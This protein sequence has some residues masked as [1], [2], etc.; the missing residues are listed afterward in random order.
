MAS[1]LIQQYRDYIKE[2]T[3]RED[4][5]PD[6][7]LAKDLVESPDGEFFLGRDPELQSA[8]NDYKEI[9]AG[10]LGDE[11]VQGAQRG[12]EQT[13]A[14]GAGS[15]GLLG[16][17][18]DSA[19]VEQGS[20]VRDWGVRK[21]TEYN[22]N[23]SQ[24]S[25]TF[26]LKDVTDPGEFVRWAASSLG[27]LAPD[28]ASTVVTT[29]GGAVIGAA[30]GNAPGAVA[31]AASGLVAGTERGIVT[32]LVR[33]QL[34]KKLGQ[35]GFEKLLKEGGEKL[36]ER[37]T[38]EALTNL[39]V[40]SMTRIAATAEPTMQSIGETWNQLAEAGEEV[41]AEERIAGSLSYGL[42]GGSL[43]SVLPNIG[44][45]KLNKWFGAKTFGEARRKIIDKAP[46]S[47]KKRV[48][49][50]AMTLGK[51]TG[52]EGLTEA[53]QELIQEAALVDKRDEKDVFD[54]KSYDWDT[55]KDR[56]IE[57]G[58]QGALGGFFF[59][60]AEAAGNVISSPPQSNRTDNPPAP[61]PT[62]D[63]Q[64]VPTAPVSVA[65][66]TVPKAASRPIEIAPESP[67]EGLDD[68]EVDVEDTAT[69]PA[70]T[71]VAD[72]TVNE[73]Q[74][75][76][77]SATTEAE[78][79]VDETPNA[80]PVWAT[81]GLKYR[82]ENPNSR[83]SD[84][85]KVFEYIVT[86]SQ[87]R[88]DEGDSTTIRVSDINGKKE[89]I[90]PGMRPSLA[91]SLLDYAKSQGYG[92][93]PDSETF[94]TKIFKSET[95]PVAPFVQI[96]KNNSTNQKVAR[97]TDHKSNSSVSRN[98]VV[99][100]D[101]S[102]GKVHARPLVKKDGGI[103]VTDFKQSSKGP[104]DFDQ[105]GNARVSYD[106]F[107]KNENIQPIEVIR[108]DMPTVERVALNFADEATYR[109]A[110]DAAEHSTSP[111]LEGKNNVPK[112]KSKKKKDLEDRTEE[113]KTRLDEAADEIVEADVGEQLDKATH[114]T[115]LTKIFNK[116]WNPDPVTEGKSKKWKSKQLYVQHLI[117]SN[118]QF[119]DS[120]DAMV[121]TKF[122][123][124]YGENPDVWTGIDDEAALKLT[125]Q[126]IEEPLVE[127]IYEGKQAEP[128]PIATSDPRR[129][130]GTEVDGRDS[131]EVR[132]Q[133][134]TETVRT[135]EETQ[136][137]EP[138]PEPELS[139]DDRLEKAGVDQMD[140]HHLR[141]YATM[142]IRDAQ[143]RY[144]VIEQS[145]KSSAEDKSRAQKAIKSIRKQWAD[146]HIFP[147]MSLDENSEEI[148][149]KLE[150]DGVSWDPN[151]GLVT[152]RKSPTPALSPIE[153]LR[154][155][156]N[157]VN[158]QALA[159]Y[160]AMADQ[161]A[162]PFLKGAPKLEQKEFWKGY[163]HAQRVTE[164]HNTLKLANKEYNAKFQDPDSEGFDLMKQAFW[165]GYKFYGD[166][167]TNKMAENDPTIHTWA[168][169]NKVPASL[170][171]G[172]TGAENKVDGVARIPAVA[173]PTSVK[174][175]QFN[176]KQFDYKLGDEE[177]AYQRLGIQEDMTVSQALEALSNSVP[178]HRLA[179]VINYLSKVPRLGTIRISIDRFPFQ[180]DEAVLYGEYNATDANNPVI[181]LNQKLDQ[182]L[183]QL[184]QTLVHEAVH[185]T[186]ADFLRNNPEHEASK[187][188]E[189]LFQL[190][191]SGN[192]NQL[193]QLGIING[194]SGTSW[195]GS[196]YAQDV[197]SGQKYGLTDVY[198]FVAEAMSNPDF[199][200]LLAGTEDPN[201]NT[202]WGNAKDTA[203]SL[204]EKFIHAVHKILESLGF[205]FPG[206]T[207][208][209]DALTSTVAGVVKLIDYAQEV[210]AYQNGAAYARRTNHKLGVDELSTAKRNVAI[211]KQED[212]LLRGLVK[213]T[214][215]PEAMVRDLIS[216]K[217]R[218][219]ETP[220][221]MIDIISQKNP[222]A[223]DSAIDN[224][225]MDD[226]NNDSAA[227]QWWD[228]IRKMQD[229]LFKT[230]NLKVTRIESAGVTLEMLQDDMKKI[231]K[232]FGDIN[233][234]RSVL[235]RRIKAF[236]KRQKLRGQLQ[237][238]NAML[239]ES[240]PELKLSDDELNELVSRIPASSNSIIDHLQALA[241]LGVNWKDVTPGEVYDAVKD[242]QQNPGYQQLTN[243]NKRSAV[244]VYNEILSNKDMA[245]ALISAGKIYSDQMDHLERRWL[246]NVDEIR[247]VNQSVRDILSIT[248][249]DTLATIIRDISRMP[250]KD[251]LALRIKQNMANLQRDYVK[252]QKQQQQW[253]IEVEAIKKLLD[254]LNQRVAAWDQRFNV[255]YRFDA[256]AGSKYVEMT[257]PLDVTG[258]EREEHVLSL[259]EGHAVTRNRVLMN[260][261]A[262][263]KINRG[264]ANPRL[265]S[266]VK[267]M[268]DKL[269]KVVIDD[270]AT[271]TFHWIYDRMLMSLSAKLGETNLNEGRNIQRMMKE[272]VA[273]FNGYINKIKPMGH[274]Y[275]A[276]YQ[277][278][279]NELGYKGHI[280]DFERQIRTPLVAMF[281]TE[282]EMYDLEDE[283]KR[284]SERIES[285]MK[286]HKPSYEFQA[287][288]IDPL[289]RRY[290]P[291]EKGMADAL[292]W[293]RE[294]L[295]L[296]VEES[297]NQRSFN[298]LTGKMEFLSRSKGVR[299]G[300]WTIPRL[301]DSGFINELAT[302]MKNLGWVSTEEQ[303]RLS[304]EGKPN[305]RE[306]LKK[307]KDGNQIK[308]LSAL[309]QIL[310]EA[311][312]RVDSVDF[313][314]M[315][316]EPHL[317]NDGFLKDSQGN[318]LS[319][320]EML[321]AWSKSGKNFDDFIAAIANIEVESQ[322]EAIEAA[323]RFVSTTVR[324][325]QN[326]YDRVVKLQVKADAE[327]NFT[328]V[329]KESSHFLTDA[330]SVE[331]MPVEY[332][333]YYNFDPMTINSHLSRLSAAKAFGIGG[334][335]LERTWDQ[336]ADRIDA[337]K[338]QADR[339]G[340]KK[341][342]L[343]LSEVEK[344]L[345]RERT[346]LK[347]F[348]DKSDFGP[349]Q[350]TKLFGEG[351]NL[352]RNGVLNN[353][354]S[355]MGNLITI[356]TDPAIAYKGVNKKTVGMTLGGM[357][358]FTKSTAWSMLES[359]GIRANISREEDIIAEMLYTRGEDDLSSED[360][361]S[362][363]GRGG[364]YDTTK[365]GKAIRTAQNITRFLNRGRG[366]RR[367]E[368]NPRNWQGFSLLCVFNWMSRNAN[369]AVARQ[370]V[371][372]YQG[373]I[374]DLRE[375]ME[376]AGVMNDPRFNLA[377]DQNALNALSSRGIF[378]AFGDKPTIK[379]LHKNAMEYF[380]VSAENLARQVAERE[381]NGEHL[382]SKSD[383]Q[384]MVQ[385]A[386]DEISLN[387]NMNTRPGWMLNSDTRHLTM[388]WGWP[389][390][391]Q[392]QV[393]RALKNEQGKFDMAL[394]YRLMT[395]GAFYVLPM[396]LAWSMALDWYDELFRDK[397]PNLRKLST[398]Q[399]F[400]QNSLASVERLARIGAYGFG[401]DFLAG[402]VSFADG[403]AGQRTISLDD[404]VLAMSALNNVTY[405]LRNALQQKELNYQTVTRPAMM[406][407]G[408]NGLIHA[409]QVINATLPGA[410]NI[411]VIGDFFEAEQ[412]VTRKI[413]VGNILR[414]VG[415]ELDIELKAG[416]GFSSPTEVSAH[417]REMLLA[418]YSND[419]EGFYRNWT[420]AVKAAYK[421]GL[422]NNPSYSL[423]DAQDS[424]KAA[425][426]SRNPM[427]AVFR[428]VP[429]DA[430]K[431]RIYNSLSDSAAAQV[432]DA[433]SSYEMFSQF[434]GVG[435]GR[436]KKSTSLSPRRNK[437]SSKSRRR[438][439]MIL[440]NELF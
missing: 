83:S 289:L 207:A 136:P 61:N 312:V 339:N 389:L 155:V 198:E 53:T 280:D 197:K 327:A 170:V 413:N 179:G 106:A 139:I 284:A 117:E 183:S 161:D 91:K 99:F 71:P 318:E 73:T 63:S 272:Y 115:T 5:R 244:K 167:I 415:R 160:D 283:V 134:R 385:M 238:V 423:K 86:E 408:G 188:I 257:N 38:R 361:Y 250:E 177:N 178:N 309:R 419:Y 438:S 219:Q 97:G 164:Q 57:A 435:G 439:S 131:G 194:G 328:V 402:I 201:K 428:A 112:D 351:M 225:V 34:V 114:F 19:N 235:V 429:S 417:T 434:I 118:N 142:A 85:E 261:R 432:R 220:L 314:K 267:F 58:A 221:E 370:N 14:I 24:Y 119:K 31:G 172:I 51:G 158:T 330:R 270:E 299:R 41:T 262:W 400:T 237:E 433:V 281:E 365:S 213:E 315:F 67:L 300:T 324:A 276:A 371:M 378:G 128:K 70:T 431:I 46:D 229:R 247:A 320:L 334:M 20:A 230:L 350:D 356:L 25:P 321:G 211:L 78:P 187:E 11:L 301:V 107:K 254:P 82:Q 341:E 52:V 422:K 84:I 344:E 9:W 30:M 62:R 275:S 75:T 35:E 121:V 48:L 425:W 307:W 156:R 269:E 191:R 317:T 416:G 149:S 376:S 424:V 127:E 94:G 199:Q 163:A 291:M 80:S 304:R 27:E 141:G 397:A 353:P 308:D 326:A 426:R 202:L 56:L 340:E 274:K 311:G 72:T 18:L 162:G 242:Y 232:D 102:T 336:L 66:T 69:T 166:N 393:H 33:K 251:K 7:F 343:K 205:D 282:F 243:E 391:K 234:H 81:L 104:N 96:L 37:E 410:D 109:Q 387:A 47:L 306:T 347:E 364:L 43:D 159:E 192:L 366:L 113:V 130:P 359:L 137:A 21:M 337:M 206:S 404:R 290:L 55:L 126:L 329:R 233:A 132:E 226:A 227:Y 252:K 436:E 368:D 342:F 36:I 278:L 420:E 253:G 390:A 189:R 29:A 331:N 87:R 111:S 405:A 255:Y 421:R 363:I 196:G 406:A 54:V 45:S 68:E 153:R 384:K 193:G 401:G 287:G 294:E 208:N 288:K 93:R 297:R 216:P 214:G 418:S 125:R 271:P 200:L 293:I 16:D 355:A 302:V 185:G 195:W 171:P 246:S 22:E 26:E 120:W 352:L 145:K 228:T 223:S 150:M 265:W 313:K 190:V 6:S 146:K 140:I 59:G 12:W 375:Y 204:L 40:R 383:I 174:A 124:V 79:V 372:V 260:N 222:T 151:E 403:S 362:N 103:W 169:R 50:A 266:S 345:N 13:K 259:D 165:R 116:D 332:F 231:V 239:S 298:P 310:A 277:A 395:I 152:G 440:P 398:K 210:D 2:T 23:S 358:D 268:T 215:L 123:E 414:A 8:Y 217:D 212:E 240:N 323:E 430:D 322:E 32:G 295:G 74:T 168:R 180:P 42:L 349:N 95:G 264:R 316:F 380:G 122:N 357:K 182:N 17:L 256:I 346:N 10:S 175:L 338:K 98:L 386:E 65:P 437:T 245:T 411:P 303:E 105:D 292:N 348:L 39:G 184:V 374:K 181:R 273:T 381:A 1:Q 286:L 92:S 388:L 354:R 249:N 325:M 412:K 248:N 76:E 367:G 64:G 333:S 173:A 218:E 209:G 110:Y 176:E 100:R 28:V 377:K 3:G 236:S 224:G 305:L 4:T 135:E 258:E 263:L 360:Y 77:T 49:N 143:A 60:G 335:E 148:L 157:K 90:A 108:L 379:K 101:T 203:F 382:F 89:G 396:G 296:G 144:E 133:G 319:S 147:E 279:A 373:F 44:L 154:A 186:T 285:L 392:A 409:V 407:L 427:N 129:S 399:S 394:T 369:F 15:I 138:D 241:S 88:Q